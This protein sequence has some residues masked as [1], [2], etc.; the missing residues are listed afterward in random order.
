MC[1]SPSKCIPQRQAIPKPAAPAGVR[2]D[3]VLMKAQ[4][5]RSNSSRKGDSFSCSSAVTRRSRNV[6]NISPGEVARRAVR[7]CR[8]FGAQ[9][10]RRRNFESRPSRLSKVSTADDN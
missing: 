2:T 10:L 7:S 4:I 8:S 3:D 5:S 9:K 6:Q 1:C